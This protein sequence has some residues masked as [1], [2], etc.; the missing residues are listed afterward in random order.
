MSKN[1]ISSG[2][3]WILP[4]AESIRELHALFPLVSMRPWWRAILTIGTYKF[5]ATF[6]GLRHVPLQYV[7]IERE[8]I[9]DLVRAGV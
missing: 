1:S 8:G 6:P 7:D 5:V 2:R 9:G 3:I 4:F